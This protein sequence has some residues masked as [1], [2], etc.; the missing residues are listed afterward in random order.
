MPPSSI[1]VDLSGDEVTSLTATVETVEGYASN[2]SLDL[3]EELFSNILTHKQSIDFLNETH[4]L[5]NVSIRGLPST[6]FRKDENVLIQWSFRLFGMEYQSE[7]KTKAT[8]RLLIR[9]S[10]PTPPLNPEEIISLV[11]VLSMVALV[12]PPILLSICLYRIRQAYRK[13]NHMFF[14]R[15]SDVGALLKK[16]RSL[17]SRGC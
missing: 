17:K 11:I 6:Y 4:V 5:F 12:L 2:I 16:V 1:A 14:V 7:G 15:L 13:N 3:N 10:P 9:A 8:T